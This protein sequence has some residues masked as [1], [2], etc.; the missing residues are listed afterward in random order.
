AR[1]HLDTHDVLFCDGHVKAYRGLT[2]TQSSAVYSYGT[3]GSVSG[4]SPTF[5]PTP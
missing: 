5:N 1:R 4:N 2:D 3:P